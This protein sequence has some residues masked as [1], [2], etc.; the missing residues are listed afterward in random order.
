MHSCYCP[1]LLTV[2]SDASFFSMCV[3]LCNFLQTSDV[4]QNIIFQIGYRCVGMR[5]KSSFKVYVC[6]CVYIYM[7]MLQYSSKFLCDSE[8]LLPGLELGN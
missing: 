5:I 8:C 7:I 2:T 3:E 1:V 4:A 6:G